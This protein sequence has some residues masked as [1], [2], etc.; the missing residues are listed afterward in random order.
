MSTGA[1]TRHIL[2]QVYAAQI[3]GRAAC[4]NEKCGYRNR[5]VA[6]HKLCAR[7]RTENAQKKWRWGPRKRNLLKGERVWESKGVKVYLGF[8]VHFINMM[9]VLVACNNAAITAKKKKKR[10]AAS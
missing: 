3:S 1:T 4:T 9:T 10:H 6:L 8:K 2:K 7:A 5:S